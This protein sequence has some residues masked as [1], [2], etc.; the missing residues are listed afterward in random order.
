VA[1]HVREHIALLD[2]IVV[3]DEATASALTLAHVCGF[4]TAIRALL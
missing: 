2:A 4:E 3:G 1:G